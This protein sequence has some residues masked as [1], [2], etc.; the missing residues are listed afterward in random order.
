MNPAQ[1]AL[2]KAAVCCLPPGGRLIIATDNDPGGDRLAA[3]IRAI[4]AEAQRPDIAVT[5]DRPQIRGQD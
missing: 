1:P 2:I 4:A 5:E 3:Q